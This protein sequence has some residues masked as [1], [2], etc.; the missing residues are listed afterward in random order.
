MEA[1][2]ITGAFDLA[3]SKSL[4]LRRLYNIYPDRPS[5]CKLGAL[6]F[7][8]DYKFLF[9]AERL[10]RTL[11][12]AGGTAF[13]CLIDEPNPWQPSNGTHHAVDLVLL[14]GGFDVSFSPAASRTGEQM[15]RAWV[16]FV[17][18]EDP[19]PEDLHAAFGPYGMFQKLDDV[20]VRSRRRLDQVSY[21]E[22]VDSEVLDK[23][24]FTLAAGRISLLN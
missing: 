6:D 18:S 1:S 5:S 21:L 22:S 4:D 24:Y 14:F 7:I 8:N 12:E 19:W 17:H 10:A 9:P 11:R 3:G 2:D 13:R 16:R 23:V 20:E 15:R